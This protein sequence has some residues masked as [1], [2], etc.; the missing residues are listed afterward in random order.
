V[1]RKGRRG[2]N[3]LKGWV[4]A[5]RHV[6]GALVP[7]ISGSMGN[8]CGPLQR[9]HSRKGRAVP[10]RCSSILVPSLWCDQPASTDG[11]GCFGGWFMNEVSRS[12]RIKNVL[13]LEMAREQARQP[14]GSPNGPVSKPS[15]QRPL[16]RLEAENAQL[17]ER[18]ADLM[19]QIQAL[20]DGGN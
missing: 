12:N 10:E 9:R 16:E 2:G 1:E 19:L 7:N 17:R 11:T 6:R 5:V 8:G 20:R 18:V 13:S 15:N 14:R 4:L 3:C